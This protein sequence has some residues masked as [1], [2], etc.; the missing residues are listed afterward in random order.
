MSVRKAGSRKKTM[1]SR[2]G[3]VF[4]G[5]WRGKQEEKARADL[6]EGRALCCREEGSHSK[7][8][9]TETNI[10]ERTSFRGER[11]GG[12]SKGVKS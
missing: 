10:S 8:H 9:C 6:A 7:R 12:K 11:G 5:K 4:A 2:K 1:G 3:K